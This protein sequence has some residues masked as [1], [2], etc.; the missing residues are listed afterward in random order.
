MPS[1]RFKEYCDVSGASG[2]IKH[3][4]RGVNTQKEMD[5]V[6]SSV[7]S[8]VNVLVQLLDPFLLPSFQQLSQLFRSH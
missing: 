7:A 2:F 3:G 4:E 6:G 8:V 1:R 5:A